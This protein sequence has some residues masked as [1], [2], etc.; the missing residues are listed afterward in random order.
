MADLSLSDSIIAIAP[1]RPSVLWVAHHH[2]WTQSLV[3]L[4][5][6]DVRPV[7]SHRG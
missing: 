1:R 3:L 6:S 4:G 2:W 7:D 5:N